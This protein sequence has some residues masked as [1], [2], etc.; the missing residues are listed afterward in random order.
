MN[1]YEITSP[2]QV[3]YIHDRLYEYNLSKTG[4]EKQEI[5]LSAV[6]PRYGWYVSCGDKNEI[7]GGLVYQLCDNGDLYVDFLWVD[8]SLRGQ[9]VGTE[10]LD[11]A[12]AKALELKRRAI[13]LFTAVY[14]APDFY[15]NYGFVLTR[16]EN[17]SFFYRMELNDSGTSGGR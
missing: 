15:R 2:A 17:D 12:K 5:I 10:L 14:Q 16:R 11:L 1:F 8:D 4:A 6:P 13:T 3:Q 9:G 7:S